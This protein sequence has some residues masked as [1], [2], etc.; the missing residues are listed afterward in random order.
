MKPL[1]EWWASEDPSRRAGLGVGAM[2]VLLIALVAGITAFNGGEG[3]PAP[4]E[5]TSALAP[6]VAATSVLPVVEPHPTDTA[7]PTIKTLKEL[8]ERFGDPPSANQGRLRIPGLGVDAPIGIRAVPASLQMPAPTGPADVVL[9]DF[10]IAPEFGGMPGA[11]GNA[12][13]SGHVDYSYKLPYANA[14]YTGLG[15][16]AL[17]RTAQPNSDQV[18]IVMGGKTLT[19]TVQWVKTVSASTGNWADILAH[20]V[21]GDAIT[22]VTCDGAFNPATQEYSDRTVLRAVR[23]S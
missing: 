5:V 23:S 7:V 18:Q 12:V 4:V 8:K 3:H 17:L 13:L 21:G 22:I 14:N 15:V 16:F 11:A 10:S 20:D 19:Y 9:Y 1:S 2:A 6:T